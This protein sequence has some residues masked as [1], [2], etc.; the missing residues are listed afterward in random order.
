MKKS[1]LEKHGYISPAEKTL[2][3]LLLITAGCLF[4]PLA[5]MLLLLFLMFPVAIS[6]IA[7]IP[8]ITYSFFKFTDKRQICPVCDDR[9]NYQD[10]H[11]MN[12]GSFCHEWCANIL[13][14]K[15]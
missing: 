5:S 14:H 11:I 6:L 4:L 12:C 10:R 3:T 2:G 9:V 13:E 15:E 1:F 7:A 8:I